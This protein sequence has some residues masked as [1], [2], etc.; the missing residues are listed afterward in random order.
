MSIDTKIDTICLSGGG[1]KG[2]SFAS[3]LNYLHNNNVINLNNI[4]HWAG[5]SA[6]AFI[7]FILIIGFTPNEF[8]DF[9][10]DFNFTKIEPEINCDTLFQKYGIDD[11]EKMVLLLS[12]FLNFKLGVKDITFID[13]FKLTNKK[14]TIIGTNYTK[15]TEEAFNHIN[16]PIMSVIKAVR[17][18]ISIPLIYT[19]VFYN[20]CFYVDG[21][22]INNFPI[23]HCNQKTTLGM[24]I[25]YG[26]DNK[27]NSIMDLISCS[28]AIITDAITEKDLID[29]LQIIQID[30]YM[31]GSMNYNLTKEDKQGIIDV[32]EKYAKKYIDELT[33]KICSDIIN[34]IINKI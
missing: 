21:A 6:G 23:K 4:T 31:S 14:I 7:S 28:M 26:K 9:I 13:L 8:N 30:N 3:A 19:P 20:S 18:S 5:T 33:T 27:L 12:H 22:L 16:T 1:I 34:D 25:K 15:G 17:I 11:G 24:Y 32:G 2:I 29:N 10:L